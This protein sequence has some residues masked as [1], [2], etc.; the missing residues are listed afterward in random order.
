[1]KDEGGSSFFVSAPMAERMS[2][3]DFP[4]FAGF[5][6]PIQPSRFSSVFV[7]PVFQGTFRQ[8]KASPAC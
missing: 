4:A 3:T 1:M 7:F 5:S 6:Y 2:Q 8:L